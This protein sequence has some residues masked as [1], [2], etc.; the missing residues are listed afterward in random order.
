MNIRTLILL[1]GCAFFIGGCTTAYKTGQTPDDVYNSPAPPQDEYANVKKSGEKRYRDY[2]SYDEDEYADYDDRY[3]RMK[4]RNRYRWSDLDDW[5]YYGNRYNFSYYNNWYYWNDPF[6]WNS[7]W[8]P[9]SY[10]NMYYNP[11]Y[12]G[13]YGGMGWGGG[14]YNPWYSGY[15]GGWGF[16]SFN[17]WYDP[18]YTGWYGNPYYYGYGP[19]VIV[20]SRVNYTQR[21]TNLNTYNPSI[22]NGNRALP[23][24]STGITREYGNGTTVTRRSSSDYG[25]YG[26]RSERSVNTNTS[27]S[28]AQGR[29][30]SIRERYSGS[31][32]NNSRSSSSSERYTPSSSRT[33]TYSRPSVD[34]RSS[35]PSYSP[36]ASSGGGGG[37]GGS[38]RGSTGGGSGRRF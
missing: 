7:P 25:T 20:G 37:G 2:E 18:W 27:N 23:D 24:R 14:W 35:T 36:P 10:W 33:E 34:T 17:G 13:W 29:A 32:Y 28:S 19:G 26:V 6:Y 8:S 15:Y 38:S 30:N 31:N 1:L 9:V 16:Y 5:Y 11:Y 3:L 4:V 22:L 12:S 21:R